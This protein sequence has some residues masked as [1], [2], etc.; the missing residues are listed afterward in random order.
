M[1]HPDYNV[2]LI[3]YRDNKKGLPPRYYE[4]NPEIKK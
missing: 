3:L 4:G 2:M 1:D